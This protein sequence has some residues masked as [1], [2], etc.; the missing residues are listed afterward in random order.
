MKII[1]IIYQLLVKIYEKYVKSQLQKHILGSCGKHV[2]FRYNRWGNHYSRI[3]LDDCTQLVDFTFISNG[4]KLII[5]KYSGAAQGFTV[6]TNIHSREVG[7]N[8]W[9]SMEYEDHS[10]S[11]KDVIIEEEVT[12]GANV[13][14]LAGVVVGRGCSIG[15]GSVLRNSTPPYSIVIGNPAKIVGFNFNPY[16]VIEHEK[17]IYD[18]EERLSIDYLEKNYQKYF[19]DRI[20][21]IREYTKL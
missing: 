8:L 13:T 10:T 15:A 16:E 19:I 20:K 2:I 18:E 3:F 1:G 14:I 6:V 7:T 4:G 21:E 9:H 5:K 17:T 11:E 12:I